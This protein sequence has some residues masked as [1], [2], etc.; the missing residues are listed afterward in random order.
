MIPFVHAANAAPRITP[1]SESVLF[2]LWLLRLAGY[3][4]THELLLRQAGP[5]FTEAMDEGTL[6][7]L[8]WSA[9]VA[10]FTF[11]KICI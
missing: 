6:L 10:D 4:H 2:P 8:P 1:L 5:I 7:A 9:Y 3:R 11:L